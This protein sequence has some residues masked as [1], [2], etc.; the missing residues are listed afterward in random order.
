MPDI[1]Y[2]ADEAG[3][4]EI[5]QSAQISDA[6]MAVAARV[7]AVAN[8]EDPAGMYVASRR[9]V[10]SGWNNTPRRGAVV[11]QTADSRAGWQR[12]ALVRAVNG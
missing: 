12:H 10:P 1:T 6:C 8:S 11:E 5:A 3:I 9:Q 7:A 2:T 4:R